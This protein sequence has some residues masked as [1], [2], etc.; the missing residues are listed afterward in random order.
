MTFPGNIAADDAAPVYVV[1]LEGDVVAPLDDATGWVAL[2][3]GADVVAF[4]NAKRALDA[5]LQVISAGASPL[6]GLESTTLDAFDAQRG[7]WGRVWVYIS[8]LTGVTEVRVRQGSS[9]LNYREWGIDPVA[10][11]LTD[12]SDPETLGWNHLRLTLLSPQPAGYSLGVVG[13]PFDINTRYLRVELD[14]PAAA[15][16]ELRISALTRDPWRYS[17]GKVIGQRAPTK[18]G[19]LVD[20][21]IGQNITQPKDGSLKGAGASV[22][23]VDAE[24]DGMPWANPWGNPWS[25]AKVLIEDVAAFAFDGRQITTLM[26]FLGEVENNTNFEP[27]YRG[28]INNQKHEGRAWSFPVVDNLRT[29]RVRFA[30]NATDAMPLIV[31]GKVW[32]VLLTLALSTGTG[33]NDPT[34]DTLAPGDGAGIPADLFDVFE[35]VQQ[36]QTYAPLDDVSFE[37]REPE[38][39]FLTWV[40]KNICLP[41]GIIPKLKADGRV[42]FTVLRPAFTGLASLLEVD[43]TNVLVARALPGFQQSRDSIVNSIRMF[44]NY[45]AATDEF[46]DDEIFQDEESIARYGERPL[47]IRSFGIKTFFVAERASDRILIRLSDGAPPVDVVTNMTLQ[48]LEIGDVVKVTLED[49]VPDLEEGVYSLV[50]VFC[51]VDG[52]GINPSIGGSN[53]LRLG[54]TSFR[55]GRYTVINCFVNDWNTATEAERI[56]GAFISCPPPGNQL[57]AETEGWVIAPG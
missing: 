32:E 24:A 50:G 15:T 5:S 36:L 47:T 18:W 7:P 14:K 35:I 41:H 20:P 27:I 29:F 40:F 17:T 54:V 25:G 42:S 30:R 13:V 46:L 33:A 11:E 51:E 8:D 49:I 48:P 34:W 52:R 57:D 26:G 9:A 16:T 2:G 3:D 37:F 1:E 44:F 39:N 55:Q 6:L 12:A 45:D 28:F 4:P 10:A 23:V 21:T 38:D 43:A 22:K 53:A 56:A 19:W 31:A